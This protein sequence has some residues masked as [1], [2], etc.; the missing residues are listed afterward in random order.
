MYHNLN[1][2]TAILEEIR[3]L[4]KEQEMNGTPPEFDIQQVYYLLA[5]VK[6]VIL[7]STRN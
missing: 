2:I 3:I 6:N 7:R 5:T 1:D 4:L